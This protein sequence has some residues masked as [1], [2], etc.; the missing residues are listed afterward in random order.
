M[1]YSNV[2]PSGT[3]TFLQ[4]FREDSIELSMALAHLLLMGWVRLKSTGFSMR[5]TLYGAGSE[6]SGIGMMLPWAK[7]ANIF[8]TKIEVMPWN[9]IF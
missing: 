1:Q 8:A 9:F 5:R 3:W 7:D 2:S 4:K 6:A